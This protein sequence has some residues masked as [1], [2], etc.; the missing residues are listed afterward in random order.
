L[1]FD[2][3]TVLLSVGVTRIIVGMDRRAPRAALPLAAGILGVLAVMAAAQPRSAPARETGRLEVVDLIVTQDR[4]IQELQAE[5]RDLE[6]QLH[7]T[8]GPTGGEADALR[9]S[10]EDLAVTAGRV[11]L[12]GPGVEVTLDDSTASRAPTGNPDDLVVHEQDIQTVVNALWASGAEAVAINGHRLSSLSAVRCAGNTLLLHGTLQTPPY[13]IVAIGDPERLQGS[14]AE[15]PGMDRLV[16]RVH[17]F[18]VRL[19]VRPGDVRIPGAAPAP[20]VER[21]TPA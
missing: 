7:D 20:V 13:E 19:E 15:G 11:A 6:A 12:A 9:R 2:L 16:S 1:D 3:G 10:A 14:F 4:R 5:V 18:G 17:T 8:T 21:A